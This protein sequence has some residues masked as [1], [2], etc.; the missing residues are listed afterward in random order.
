MK[1]N[2]NQETHHALT[3]ANTFLRYYVWFFAYLLI[4]FSATAQQERISAEFVQKP[5]EEVINELRDKSGLNFIFNHEE[6][7]KANPVTIKLQNISIKD[8]LTKILEGSGLT[9]EII[10]KTVVIKPEIKKIIDDPSILKQTLRG[11][12]IDQESKAGLPF[13][14]VLVLGT[15]P[16]IGAT[17]DLDGNFVI[18]ELPIGRYSI[19]VSFIGYEDAYAYEILV[20]SG[21]EQILEF[22]LTE[23]VE[24]LT[25][26]VIDGSKEPLNE[27]AVVSAK[28]FNSEETKR[29]A[30]SISDPARMAQTFAGVS[31]TDDATNEIVI[32]GNSPNWLLWRIEGVEIPSPNHF[33]EEGYSAGAV[34]ILSSNML[35]MSDFYTGAFP[36]EYG[37][38]LSGVFDIN[39]RNG[40]NKTNE[41]TFQ[42][43][44]LGVD[45][46]AEGPFKKGDDAS[47]LFNYRYST[48]SIL[49]N[50]N[51]QISENALPNYQ[52]L[53][54]KLNFPTKKAGIFSLWG[55]GGLSD[56]DEKYVP[57]SNEND[58]FEDGYSDFTKTGMYATG[59]SHTFFPDNDSYFYSVLSSSMSY[60]SEDF[61]DM[62]TLGVLN[63]RFFDELQ[64][65]AIRFSSYYNRKVSSQ[66][67][68]R[69]GIIINQLNYNYYTRERMDS[70][71]WNTYLDINSHTR[72][73]QGYFQTKY[74][75]NN[76]VVGTAGLH[77][78]Y[79]E[80]SNDHS[81][82]PRMG[83][84]VKL[85][86]NQKLTFGY[87][88]HSRHE[89]LPAY[90]V[91]SDLNDGS[92][93]Y[94]NTNLDLTRASHYVAGYEKG[95]GSNL[96]FKTEIYYQ[97]IGNLPVSANPEKYG[98]P[99][100]GGLNFEDTLANIG[101]GRNY[102]L[103]LTLQKYFSNQYYFLLTSSIFDSKYKAADG[104]W[105]NSRYNVQYVNNLVGGKE[106]S[107]GE[108]K[109]LGLNA[110][111]IWSGGKRQNPID[112]SKS[113]EE[114]TT[115]YVDNAPWS[116]QSSDYFRIDIGAKLHFFKNK[117]EQVIMLDIQNVTNRLN[118]W[119]QFYDVKNQQIVDYPM[120]GLIP[121]LS[122]RLEF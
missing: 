84:S 39:L 101:K 92:S 34:S 36:A 19:K 48:L 69:T 72:L 9:F 20:G 41:Y 37:N 52:D 102:G 82:E 58:E 100:F 67:S 63:D 3:W 85:P 32:R 2:L 76:N 49:N 75:F 93:F 17:T 13:A 8:A 30:A 114:G 7:K 90:F 105:Y 21:K 18:E 60:S 104:K 25:E 23:K 43:G 118:T 38:A 80:L 112:V 33:A 53:S 78:S 99:I 31:G 16:M 65:G 98:S 77:Y 47:F 71:V 11:H 88:M 27:M 87:G 14:T 6:L 55:I 108:N 54:F 4:S 74:K 109:L 66:T 29:F 91:K 113:I 5:L 94:P 103:E 24:S 111:V 86:A 46:S 79:F 62:D 122:Y 119:V 15:D 45:L 51:I 64:R 117:R 22:S 50:L 12:V 56:V 70:N 10:N 1:N 68:F 116:L 89:N 107:L 57:T 110:K 73:Y 44:V 115:V 96:H 95:F 35:G 42:A 106:F 83:L 81:I 121:V 28:S 97:H 40:N 120:A 26:L 61:E 59:L